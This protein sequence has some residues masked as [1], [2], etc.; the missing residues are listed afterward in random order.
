MRS[1]IEE[2]PLSFLVAVACPGPPTRASGPDFCACLRCTN[3]YSCVNR[4][5]QVPLDMPG[6]ENHGTNRKI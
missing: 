2:V 1:V 6:P 4:R 3:F 5:I